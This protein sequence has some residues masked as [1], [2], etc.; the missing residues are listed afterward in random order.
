MRTRDVDC[1]ESKFFR[2]QDKCAGPIT[3]EPFGIDPVFKRGAE[4]FNPDFDFVL[5]ENFDPEGQKIIEFYNC[6]AIGSSDNFCSELYNQQNLP[7][8]FRP[9]PLETKVGSS[10]GN[11]TGGLY[12]AVIALPGSESPAAVFFGLF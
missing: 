7:Y 11:K 9:F 2:I 12:Q 6:S 4:L 8:A 1:T 3:T 5:N 10:G